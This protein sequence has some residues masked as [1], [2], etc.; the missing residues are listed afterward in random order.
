V[1]YGYGNLE[2]MLAAL[3]AMLESSRTYSVP[4]TWGTYGVTGLLLDSSA[5]NM[6]HRSWASNGTIR[7]MLDQIRRTFTIGML[8]GYHRAPEWRAK[9]KIGMNERI[10]LMGPFG[11]D[12]SAQEKAWERLRS[13]ESKDIIPLNNSH[14]RATRLRF[15]GIAIQPHWRKKRRWIVDFFVQYPREKYGSGWELSFLCNKN[16]EDHGYPFDFSKG[17]KETLTQWLIRVAVFVES[18]CTSPKKPVP[19]LKTT[20]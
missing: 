16:H 3:D 4:D 18:L 6:E 19:K 12:V 17:E 8:T 10:R 11:D 5:V 20:A 2:I 14:K 9:E 7:E 15:D 1:P 13:L